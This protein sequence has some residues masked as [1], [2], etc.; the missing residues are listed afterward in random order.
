MILL[1][2]HCSQTQSPSP[3]V[4][5]AKRL[6][7]LGNSER[8][9]IV[10]FSNNKCLSSQART[11]T[12]NLKIITGNHCIFLTKWHKHMFTTDKHRFWPMCDGCGCRR[13]G[14]HSLYFL[15]CRVPLLPMQ[16]VLQDCTTESWERSLKTTSC[17]KS[18]IL[19]SCI[20]TC[21]KVWVGH[22]WPKA[23]SKS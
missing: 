19:W 4:W 16:P 9:G 11:C 1:L 20:T 8:R 7:C 21:P 6:T 15:L 3:K 14:R 22:A 12:G 23:Y 5:V 13:Q 18:M 2:Y 17:D 10:T